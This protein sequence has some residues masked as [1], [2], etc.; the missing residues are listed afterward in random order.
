LRLDLSYQ[1]IMSSQDPKFAVR[2]QMV[3][4]ALSKG[5]RPTMRDFR[6][7]RNTVRLWLRRYQEQGLAGLE[8]RS[9]A[10]HHIP[11]QNPARGRAAGR[12][13]SRRHPLLWPPAPQALL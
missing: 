13:G 12:R 3:M 11:P 1:Q 5:I 7:S 10:P 8:E 2:Y 4:S 6:C 9:R